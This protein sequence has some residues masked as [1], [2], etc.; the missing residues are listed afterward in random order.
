VDG[1]ADVGCCVAGNGCN[2]DVVT[3]ADYDINGVADVLIMLNS[4][5][6]VSIPPYVGFD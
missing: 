6:G 3:G 2:V 5:A 4:V 1:L